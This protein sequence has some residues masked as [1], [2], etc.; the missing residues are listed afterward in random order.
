MLVSLH[1]TTAAHSS[2]AEIQLVGLFDHHWC[3]AAQHMNHVEFVIGG[4]P[5]YQKRSVAHKHAI[6]AALHR[7]S[8]TLIS[9]QR[10][11]NQTVQLLAK[12]VLLC[13]H[14]PRG[15]SFRAGLASPLLSCC[16]TP[17]TA[18]ATHYC[19]TY[20]S[21]KGCDDTGW[22]YSVA[23]GLAYHKQWKS[24]DCFILACTF[25]KQHTATTRSAHYNFPRLLNQ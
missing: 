19:T 12:N 6:C 15:P 17:S 18:H 5:S 20:S 3:I 4:M 24:E 16:R 7:P 14:V 11:N 1:T 23:L 9:Q 25:R 22:P 10:Y 21:C 13:S 8:L 2:S